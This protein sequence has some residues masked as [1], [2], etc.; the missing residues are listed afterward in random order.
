MSSST[1]TNG[2]RTT[3]QYEQT[4]KYE[5]YAALYDPDYEEGVT[6]VKKN[7]TKGE[8][9]AKPIEEIRELTDS[10]EGLE[11]GF[12]TTYQ[13]RAMK[14]FGSSP[15]CAPSMTRRSSRMC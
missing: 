13:P 9:K 3:T 11:A 4:D 1:F 14:A 15:P 10:A 8:G 12:A 6:R 7:R 2:N 5:R